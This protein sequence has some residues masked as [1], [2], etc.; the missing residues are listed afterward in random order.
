M[1]GCQTVLSLHRFCGIPVKT[2]ID[3]LKMLRMTT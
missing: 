2:V 1:N 3:G